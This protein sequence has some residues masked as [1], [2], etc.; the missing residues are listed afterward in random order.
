VQTCKN[1]RQRQEP[2]NQ[3]IILQPSNESTHINQSFESSIQSFLG[4]GSDSHPLPASS[5][6]DAPTYFDQ[7]NPSK[8]LKLLVARVAS[9]G[10]K[11]NGDLI[12]LQATR[13]MAR[14]VGIRATRAGQSLQARSSV[15]ATGAVRGST[16]AESD[17]SEHDEIEENISSLISQTNKDASASRGA[18]APRRSDAR[19]SGFWGVDT[20]A[21]ERAKSVRL[22]PK[23][24]EPKVSNG[25]AAMQ[26][27][28]AVVEAE[29]KAEKL[30]VSETC[31][32][33]H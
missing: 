1:T 27:A 12:V 16:L 10:F 11:R 5:R 30:L 29:E 13:D 8:L 14:K 33:I 20:S 17:S 3:P 32:G 22:V 6:A 26:A 21:I 19:A 23:V 24:N 28:M 7:Q 9:K 31:Y 25:D 15:M 2:T 4:P 18:N